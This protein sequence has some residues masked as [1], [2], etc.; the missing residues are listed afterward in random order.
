[1][2]MS[3]DNKAAEFARARATLRCQ[4][5]RPLSICIGGKFVW[6]PLVCAPRLCVMFTWPLSR[7]RPSAS[8][9]SAREHKGEEEAESFCFAK[10]ATARL[11]TSARALSS[12]FVRSF[13]RSLCCCCCFCLPSEAGSR[14][15]LRLRSSPPAAT[16]KAYKRR[17]NRQRKTN[18]TAQRMQ[19]LESAIKRRSEQDLI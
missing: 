14:L 3:C 10:V 2:R 12:L 16:V 5:L 1:M 6:L 17:K 7:W 19:A 15:R 4:F 18:N 8:F 11:F 9:A 13:V